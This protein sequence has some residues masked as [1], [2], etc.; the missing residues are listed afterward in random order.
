M[1]PEF[2]R[3]V[4]E[5]ASISTSGRWTT[6]NEAIERLCANPGTGNEWWVQVFASLCAQ[7]FS[8]Y[9]SLKHSYEGKSDVTS[10]LAWRARNLLELSMWSLYCSKSR[11]NAWRF[12]EDAGRDVIGIFDAFTKWGTA[13][14][15]DAVWLADIDNGKKN[16]MARQAIA[17]PATSPEGRFKDVREAAEE[18]GFSEHFKVGFKMLSK[19]THPTSMQILGTRTPVQIELQNDLYFSQGCLCFA[20]AFNAL[21]EQILQAARSLTLP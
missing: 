10:L 12:Y 16:E 19:F 1:D 8:E 20:G 9:L 2:S 7:V 13:T 5:A 15:Q 6:V 17:H 18:V 21:E 14:G 3:L 4:V 11:E